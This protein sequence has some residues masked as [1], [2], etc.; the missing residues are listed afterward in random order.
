MNRD[1]N[2]TE[3]A[4]AKETKGSEA[5]EVKDDFEDTDG[6]DLFTDTEDTDSE[7]D[8][9]DVEDDEG[10]DDEEDAAEEDADE[11]E[12]EAEDETEKKPAKESKQGAKSK[13]PDNTVKPMLKVTHNGKE[14]EI[15]PMSERAKELIQKGMNYNHIS[16]KLAETEKVLTEYGK[17]NGG[18]NAAEALKTLLT[19]VNAAAVEQAAAEIKKEFPSADDKLVKELA[20]RRAAEKALKAKQTED[21]TA[22]QT[23]FAELQ[24]EYPKIAKLE[25]L[26]KEVQD[27][28]KGGKTP[29][30]AMKDHEIA[31]LKKEAAEQKAALEAENQ[32]R[33]NRDSTIGSAKGT[34]GKSRKD[35]FETGLGL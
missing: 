31:T 14:E 6:S 1:T 16:E 21:A 20:E 25:D 26:P 7:E 5:P 17:M 15:D 18:L 24:K 30:L 33:K 12:D 2:G 23:Q 11:A 22:E 29:L 8:G 9:E 28:V 10:N 19:A 34:A 27:A 13:A 4:E 35:S 32:N 3:A